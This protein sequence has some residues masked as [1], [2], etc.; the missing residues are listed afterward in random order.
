MRY[1]LFVP[2]G[3]LV[4]G[5][6]GLQGCHHCSHQACAPPCSPGYA[7]AGPAPLVLPEHP[8]TPQGSGPPPGPAVVVPPSGGLVAPPSGAPAPAPTMPDVRGYGPGSTWQPRA[9]GGVRLADPET[10][11]SQ[12]PPAAPRLLPP[13]ITE[14]PAPQ[15]PEPPLAQPTRPEPLPERSAAPP[16]PVGIPQFGVARDQVA[17]GL[18]PSLDGLDWLQAKGYRTVLHL[19]A[20]GESDSADRQVVEKHGLKYLSLEVS[21]ETLSR[22]V[23]DQFT[24]IVSDSGN[25]PVFVY[26]RDGM[27]AGGLWYLYFRTAEQQSD[28]VARMRAARLGLKEEATGAH[29]TM[30]VA[31]QKYL[32]EQGGAPPNS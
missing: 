3:L 20:P 32:S 2:A 24:R 25:F 26:D 14:K 31:I 18:K 21:P 11:P 23:V 1:R 5:G 17:S 19:K 28:E 13:E 15:T 8:L 27:L 6:L 22:A 7:A 9:D 16:L 29:R 12:S 10:T 4:L 30:W